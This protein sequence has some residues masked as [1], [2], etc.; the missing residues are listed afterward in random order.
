MMNIFYLEMFPD[1]KL[2]ELVQVYHWS[3]RAIFFGDQEHSG[4][5]PLCV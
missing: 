2:I 1:D 5:E 4:Q 3:L